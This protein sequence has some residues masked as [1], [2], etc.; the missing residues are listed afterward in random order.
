MDSEKNGVENRWVVKTDALNIPVLS[1]PSREPEAEQVCRA[2]LVCYVS[3]SRLIYFDQAKAE[4]KTEPAELFSER[5]GGGVI[6]TKHSGA[7]HH[8]RAGDPKGISR[9]YL[10]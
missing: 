6:P 1:L 9:R 3:A 2:L 7:S 8:F 10:P 4:T 5:V